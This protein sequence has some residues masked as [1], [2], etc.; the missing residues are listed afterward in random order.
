MIF[1]VAGPNFPQGLSWQSFRNMKPES[2]NPCEPSM[3]EDPNPESRKL[4]DLLQAA[5]AKL[6]PTPSELHLH[7]HTHGHDGKSFVSEHS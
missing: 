1:D 5:D 4:Y 6:Y 2:S 3:E 7:V